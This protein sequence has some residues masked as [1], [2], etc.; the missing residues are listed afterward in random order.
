MLSH[1]YSAFPD[2]MK[3]GDASLF[4]ALNSVLVDGDCDGRC[5]G[6]PQH[7]FASSIRT[8]PVQITFAATRT[9][10]EYDETPPR[11]WLENV[12]SEVVEP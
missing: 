9:V 8:T 6:D 3:G 2:E 1:F 7:P 10:D 12:E 11:V 5:V 4:A